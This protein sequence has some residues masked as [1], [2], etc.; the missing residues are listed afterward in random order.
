MLIYSG[1]PPKDCLVQPPFFGISDRIVKMESD[2]Q[3]Q[4]SLV[5][6]S[7]AS[8]SLQEVNDT[9]D[10]LKSEVEQ[11]RLEIKEIRE[12]KKNEESN[13]NIE[14]H[15]SHPN[16]AKS[17]RTVSKVGP[18][19]RSTGIGTYTFQILLGVCIYSFQMM[20]LLGL[21]LAILMNAFFHE[22]SSLYISYSVLCLQF[23]LF[24]AIFAQ[25]INTVEEARNLSLLRPVLSMWI[26]AFMFFKVEF[27]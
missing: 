4:E 24:L 16:Y 15:I 27:C 9:L 14:Q 18:R 22:S 11:L 20:L 10:A 5:Q 21:S 1:I 23:F 17:F 26:F 3:E 7:D 2:G 19:P 8:L 6:Q 25:E 12:Q 13:N